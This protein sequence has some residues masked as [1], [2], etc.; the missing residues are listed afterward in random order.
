MPLE[1]KGHWGLLFSSCLFTNVWNFQFLICF[2]VGE[3]RNLH[4]LLTSMTCVLNSTKYWCFL[5]DVSTIYSENNFV[6]LLITYLAYSVNYLICLLITT[7]INQ[8][9]LP[10]TGKNLLLGPIG[11]ERITHNS[12]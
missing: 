5:Y 2:S 11:F 4:Q 7:R 3:K 9:I 8:S 12:W 10:H 6:S 1:V